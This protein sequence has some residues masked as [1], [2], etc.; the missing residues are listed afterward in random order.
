M[1]FRKKSPEEK[2]EKL[3]HRKDWSRLADY[4]YGDENQKKEL[5]QALAQSDDESSLDLLLRLADV[6]VAANEDDVLKLSVGEV[7]D[8]QIMQMISED[9]TRKD[10][11]QLRKHFAYH[12]G[13]SCNLGVSAERSGLCYLTGESGGSHLTACHAVNGVVDKDYG[14]VFASGSCV[15]CFAGSDSGKVAVTLICEYELVGS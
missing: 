3:V 6:A 11:D 1:L 9:I 2:M 13:V 4:V 10:T 5:A 15:N 7:Q 8:S 14:D 12:Y